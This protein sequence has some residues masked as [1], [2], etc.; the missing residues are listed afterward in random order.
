MKPKKTMNHDLQDSEKQPPRF[1]VKIM[2]LMA[3]MAPPDSSG[4][5]PKAV[6]AFKSV[7]AVT[8]VLKGGPLKRRLLSPLRGK[9]WPVAPGEFIVGEA[10]GRIA[11]CTLTSNELIARLASLPGVAI[12]GRVYTVN[13]GIERIILNLTANPQ[14]RILVLCGKESPIFH[15]AQGLRALFANGV[16]SNHRIIGAEGHLPV[17]SNLSIDHI[18]R[19]RRQI[20]L[21]DHTG[22]TDM[23]S[24]KSLIATAVSQS[25]SLP[26]INSEDLA[27]VATAKPEFKTLET[28]GHREPLAYDL[29][30]FFVINLDELSG[31][32][33]CRHYKHDN[34]PAH[35][36]RARSAERIVLALVREGLISQISHA[37]YIGAELAKAETALQLGLLYEQDKR[38]RAN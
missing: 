12:A 18:E 1:L 24:L 6:R 14:I 7:E 22:V 33:V 2:E 16:S 21:I 15:P 23:D 13:L 19:F 31:E 32:I 29:K 10:D 26:P 36:L 25:T 28:G 20:T 3:K 5:N 38:L 17:L 11:V 37:G 35:E 30:G 34:T 8:D 9:A 27:S 4:E